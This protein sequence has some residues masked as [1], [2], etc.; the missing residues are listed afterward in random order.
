MS[1][2]IGRSSPTKSAAE[3]STRYRV[4]KRRAGYA[5]SGRHYSAEIA[6]TSRRCRQRLKSLRAAD[7]RSL[8]P[9]ASR[10]R[11]SLPDDGGL[12]A[13]W[14]KFIRRRSRVAARRRLSPRSHRPFDALFKARCRVAGV[15]QTGLPPAAIRSRVAEAAFY[16][17]PYLRGKRIGQS[18][19]VATWPRIIFAG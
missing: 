14:Q 3:E 11:A 5:T 7:E 18:T 19:L 2:S 1:Q 6:A 8:P 16:A 10:F 15:G 12:M 9:Y 13:T 17:L 4:V